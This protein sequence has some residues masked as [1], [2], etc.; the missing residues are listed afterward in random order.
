MMRPFTCLCILLAG[1]AG[2]YVYQSK[3]QAQLLDREIARVVKQADAARERAGVLRAEYMLLNDPTRLQELASEHLPSLRATA[4]SQFTIWADLEK[5]LPPVGAP[6]EAAPPLEPEAP[7]A[8]LPEPAVPEAPKPAAPSGGESLVASEAA[9]TP[10]AAAARAD[11]APAR[12]ATPP[13][14]SPAAAAAAAAA[15]PAPPPRPVAPAPRPLSAPVSLTAT[16][17]PVAA[18]SPAP[19]PAYAAVPATW[20]ALARPAPRTMPTYTPPGS[21]LTEA[22]AHI[23][24]TD[25]GDAAA[26]MVGSA[27]GMARSLPPPAPL[28][29]TS[30]P[31]VWQPGGGH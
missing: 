12:P 15:R 13:A 24:R 29:Q 7:T 11:S 5:R 6:A 26:P 17:P 25:A 27:L 2:L 23:A 1:G 18:P 4:P 30:T 21:N 20:S 8:K 3:H 28:V 16:L 22:M 14:S 10:S 31:A 19:A 9:A